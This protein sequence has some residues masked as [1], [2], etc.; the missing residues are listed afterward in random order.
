MQVQQRKNQAAKIKSK[1]DLGWSKRLQ[2]QRK[3]RQRQNNNSYLR[4]LIMYFKVSVE[5]ALACKK[6]KRRK[7]RKEKQSKS[8]GQDIPGLTEVK[9]LNEIQEESRSKITFATPEDWL[10]EVIYQT[11][12]KDNSQY[13]KKMWKKTKKVL[14]AKW[15]YGMKAQWNLNR[16]SLQSAVTPRRR[17][18]KN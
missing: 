14:L 9:A 1:L 16:N 4:T 15:I 11:S 7:I 10:I 2:D 3:N 6:R 13:N 8:K 5:L 18:V 12:I 17:G